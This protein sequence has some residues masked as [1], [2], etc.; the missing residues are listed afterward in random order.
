METI[1][2]VNL[3]GKRFPVPAR[4]VQDRPQTLLGNQLQLAKYYRSDRNDYYFERSPL[5]FPY[6]FTYYTLDKKIFCPHHIP[7]EL[8]Q[9][10]CEFFQLTDSNIYAEINC[11]ATYQ[12]F[13]QSPHLNKEFLTDFAPLI[14]GVVFLI[15]TSME[16]LDRSSSR[17]SWS[18]VYFLELFSTLFLTSA[19]AYRSIFQKQILRK[20][21]FLLDLF[22]AVSSI[23]LMVLQNF[24]IAS[25]PHW[26]YILTVVLKTSR[27]VI[28][29]VHLR[30]LRLV[31]RTFVQR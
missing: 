6:I 3:L 7:M 11:A 23:I 28:V 2:T 15:I 9:R 31:V 8:L 1:L 24:L 17:S 22:A 4:L 14:I 25:S 27:S 13:R 18:L 16:R 29:V 21:S 19:I 30:L 12:Y 20:P 10:E 5:L 26:I